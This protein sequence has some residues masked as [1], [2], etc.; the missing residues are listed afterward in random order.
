MLLSNYT[1]RGGATVS[2]GADEELLPVE[3]STSRNR[4]YKV[5]YYL[6]KGL[7]NFWCD[8]TRKAALMMSVGLTFMASQS[9]AS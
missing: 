4:L 6:K 2:V 7:D 5:R 9:I 8:A 3:T 1:N